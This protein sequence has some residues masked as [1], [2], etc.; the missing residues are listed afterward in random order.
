MSVAAPLPASLCAREGGRWAAMGAACGPATALLAARLPPPAYL[1][2][3]V[4]VYVIVSLSVSVRVR[5]PGVATTTASLP[6]APPHRVL[7]RRGARL[8]RRPPAPV[9]SNT[10]TSKLCDDSQ[11]RHTP[12]AD[13]RRN[14]RGCHTQASI[15]LARSHNRH[16]DMLTASSP[17]PWRPCPQLPRQSRPRRPQAGPRRAQRTPTAAEPAPRG[18]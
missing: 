11:Q 2:L 15:V 12:P 3:C 18:R 1:A 8:A 9:P 7:S 5:V 10:I 14:N 16:T 13:T 17:C 6:P 4:C